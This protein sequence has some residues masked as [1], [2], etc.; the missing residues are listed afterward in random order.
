MAKDE[1]ATFLKI[2][3]IGKIRTFKNTSRGAETAKY[4][5]IATPNL[6]LPGLRLKTPPEGYSVFL[7]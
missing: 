4:A 2:H 5:E 1:I 3:N 7:C 6:N